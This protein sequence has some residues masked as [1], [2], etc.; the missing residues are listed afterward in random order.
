MSRFTILSYGTPESSGS[1]MD[2]IDEALRGNDCELKKRI[3]RTEDEL[4]EAVKDV[5][6][7]LEG[8]ARLPAHLVD[9]LP[10]RIRV[11]GAGGIGVDFVDV[12]AGMTLGLLINRIYNIKKR[13]GKHRSMSEVRLS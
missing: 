3:Y 9:A 4:M 10:E 13:I 12:E 11:I 2:I 1:P 5:D 8:G 6:G 7:I